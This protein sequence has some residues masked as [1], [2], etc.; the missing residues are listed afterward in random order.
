MNETM[1]FMTQLLIRIPGIIIAVTM[2]EY[3]K[4]LASTRLGDTLPKKEGRLSLN[5]LKQ[6]DPLGA[7]CLLVWGYGWGNPVNTSP[8]YYRNRRRDTVIA[9]ATPS[10]C[11]V[12]IGVAF[13]LAFNCFSRAIPIGISLDAYS[14]IQQILASIAI[15]N[16]SYGLFQF[17]PVYPLNGAKIFSVLAPADVAIKVQ[18]YEK[19]LQM[20]LVICIILGAADYLFNPL[21]KLILGI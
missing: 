7:I 8:M 4:A 10:L 12:I 15:Y 1:K 16:V 19:L 2:H 14:I 5:P 17:V 18:Q 20:I 13:G 6:M 11:N 3:V 21:T 9:H